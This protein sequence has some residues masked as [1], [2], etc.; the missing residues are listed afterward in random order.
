MFQIESLYTIGRKLSVH[1]VNWSLT[2]TLGP[3]PAQCPLRFGR[4]NTSAGEKS[5]PLTADE[6]FLSPI[7]SMI[8]INKGN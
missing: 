8:F 1:Y 2:L 4:G 6:T 5:L 7:L 3:C